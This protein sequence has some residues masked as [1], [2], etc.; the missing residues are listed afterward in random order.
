MVVELTS[1]RRKKARVIGCQTYEQFLEWAG[2]DTLA[3]W[4]NGR[5]VWREPESAA[6][7]DLLGFL[8]CILDWFVEDHHSGEVM[9]RGYPMKLPQSGREPDIMFIAQE[10]LSRM[11]HRYLDGPA[12]IAVEIISPESA[13]RDRGAKYGEYEAGGVR[14]HWVFDIEAKR[15]DFFVL[16]GDGRYERAHP[17]A[18]GVYHSAV[19]PEF[20]LNVNW[21]WEQPLPP[22]RSV[23][24]AWKTQM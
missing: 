20:W 3:E 7:Q 17:A 13:L 21:L 2:E 9:M 14:E 4:V 24:Q 19:L 18:D 15:A 12:D 8:A 1:H 6:H 5:V 22:L 10:N 23:V 16:G 11:T